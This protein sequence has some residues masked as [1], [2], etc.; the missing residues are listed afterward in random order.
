MFTRCTECK[1]IHSL[2]LEQLRKSRGM[3]RCGECSAMFDALTFISETE[4]CDEGIEESLVPKP[5]PWDVTRQKNARFWTIGLMSG[6]L[7]LAVQLSYFEGPA[8]IQY[9]GFRLWAENIC[10]QLGW[11]LPVYKNADEF[12]ILHRS[13]TL[14]PD[15]NY[16]LNVVFSNQAPFRQSY[17]NFHLTLLNF[18]GQVFAERVFFPSDYL[19]GASAKS[20]I[21]ADATEEISLKILAP[22]TKIGGYDFDF[23]Y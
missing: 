2:S 8:I 16:L 11:K 14:L 6:L 18:N 20:T 3:M 10:S 12:E 4:P 19:S 1:A 23:S 21:A 22:K 5:L 9:P 15:Q 13:L 7:L 17:P